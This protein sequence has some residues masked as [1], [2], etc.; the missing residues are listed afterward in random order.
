[1]SIND[2]STLYH[3]DRTVT[4]MHTTLTDKLEKATTDHLRAIDMLDGVAKALQ[5][6]FRHDLELSRPTFERLQSLITQYVQI[7][8]KRIE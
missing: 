4:A 7:S 1:M 6:T 5:D 2:T 8:R 3:I